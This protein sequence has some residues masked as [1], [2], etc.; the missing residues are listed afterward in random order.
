MQILIRRKSRTQTKRSYLQSG[1]PHGTQTN[2]V[3]KAV[4]GVVP[5]RLSSRTNGSQSQRQT[6]WKRR[7][8]DTRVY[9]FRFRWR[10]N[11]VISPL[12]C[13]EQADCDRCRAARGQTSRGGRR[14]LMDESWGQPGA[15]LRRPGSRPGDVVAA[16]VRATPHRSY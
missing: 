16:D 10:D 5:R 12:F 11:D 14:N 13:F 1:I 8:R 7:N 15:S 9:G 6:T 4:A 3:S 2:R